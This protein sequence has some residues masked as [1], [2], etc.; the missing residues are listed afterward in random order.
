MQDYL[1]TST[2]DKNPSSVPYEVNTWIE[3]IKWN[4]NEEYKSREVHG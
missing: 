2:W 3:K 1:L 4:N